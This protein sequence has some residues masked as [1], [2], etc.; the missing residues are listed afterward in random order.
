[1]K[2]VVIYGPPAA[3]KL[4]VARALS[5]LINYK[6][7]HNHLTV[8]LVESVL[9]FDK[10]NFWDY[11][12]RFRLDMLKILAKEKINIIFTFCYRPEYPKLVKDLVKLIKKHKG[13]IYFVQLAPSEEILLKRV[14]GASRKKYGKLKSVTQ[15]KKDLKTMTFFE[16]VPYKENLK[17]DNTKLPA[18]QV[19]KL[20]EQHF[21][22]K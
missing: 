17:I 11:V 22:L 6:V 5:K 18:K 16:S 8:D 2:L 7:F 15:L 3:G 13:K 19:A 12:N 14:K 21:K 1:M 20:I 10:G 9:E 4:T